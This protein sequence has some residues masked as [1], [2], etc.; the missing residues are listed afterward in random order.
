MVHRTLALGETTAIQEVGS[1][2]LAR[3]QE[4]PGAVG[5]G[6]PERPLSAQPPGGG[7]RCPPVLP[8]P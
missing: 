4:A 7:W 6:S 5:P 2:P 3:M 1:K 8:F